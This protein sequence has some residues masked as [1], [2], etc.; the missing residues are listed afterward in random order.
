[1]LRRSILLI[2]LMMLA[3]CAHRPSP[4]S[5]LPVIQQ[6]RDVGTFNRVKVQGNINISLH[7]GYSKPKVILIGAATDLANVTTTLS[8]NTLVIIAGKGYPKHGPVTAK[9]HGR[10]LNRFE[11]QGNGIV[12]GT[13]I[14]SNLIDFV[15]DND[16]GNIILG[17]NL[18]VR[19]LNITSGTVDIS[20][21]RSH[22]LM[23]DLSGNANVKLKGMANVTSLTMVDKA[24]LS[25]YWV[26]SKALVVRGYDQSYIQLAGITDKLD[27]ELCDKARFHGRYLRAER[28]FVKTFNQSVAEISAVKRQHT[29]A[30]D[31]SDIHFYNIP[32]MRT[33]FLAFDGSV[34]DM[35][36]LRMPFI[37]EYTHYNKWI[38][39]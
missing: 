3:G 4:P 19:K 9:V 35:R 15:L 5:T 24:Q 16:K 7:S 38:Q 11:Y 18:G 33:D 20:G 36:D 14:N 2:F 23:M 37:Q 34:L 30:S 1:M 8:N 39:M 17:G 22:N 25:F 10:F 13:K 29:L 31:A 6:T 21:V 27:V 12:K 26:N 32:D 28:A